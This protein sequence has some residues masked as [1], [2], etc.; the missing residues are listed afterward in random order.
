MTFALTAGPVSDTIWNMSMIQFTSISDPL[1]RDPAAA[2]AAVRV[3]A[4]AHYLRLL[5]EI[6]GPVELDRALLLATFEGL[7][8]AGVAQHAG[9]MLQQATEPGDYRELLDAALDQI[10]HCPLPD[11]EWASVTEVLTES[12]LAELVAISPVSLRR[13][14][15][16]TRTTPDDVA[17]RLHFL[18]LLIVDLSGAYNDHGIRRWFDRPRQALGGRRPRDLLG[19]S[20]D[21]DAPDTG[22]LRDLA[23]A[24]VGA[25]AGAT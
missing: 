5:G 17:L 22:R 13:Y 10:E 20:F 8:A 12:L 6:D 16:G 23:A 25:K 14:A 18:A 15:A 4:W 2:R 21:P 19:A 9:L 7:S 11:A 1:A 3:V 24:L